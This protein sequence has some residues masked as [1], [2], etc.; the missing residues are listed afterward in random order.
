VGQPMVRKTPAASGKALTELQA[1]QDGR[2][3]GVFHKHFARFLRPQMNS[4]P[5][6]RHC[7]LYARWSDGQRAPWAVSNTSWMPFSGQ[8]TWRMVAPVRCTR[9][10]A[11]MN[12]CARGA[13]RTRTVWNFRP[14]ISTASSVSAEPREL[15]RVL[16]LCVAGC[17]WCA[18]AAACLASARRSDRAA[19]RPSNSSMRRRGWGRSGAWRVAGLPPLRRVP[20]SFRAARG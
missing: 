3:R 18:S 19:R 15:R 1:A 4:R 8:S 12:D 16:A 14:S 7:N 17:M 6:T 11:P 9:S 2:R 13:H 10:P 5:P 20:R